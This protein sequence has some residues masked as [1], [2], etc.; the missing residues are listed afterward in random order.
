MAM[1]DDH[2]LPFRDGEDDEKAEGEGERKRLFE[3]AIPEIFKRVVERAVVAG[4]GKLAE[5][6]ESIR[7]LMG[8]MK[9]PKEVLS[10]IYTQIDDTK[11]DLYRVVAK[12]IRDVFERMQFADEIAKVLTKLS[13]EIRTEIRFIPNDAGSAAARGG[14]GE[15]DEEGENADEGEAPRGA[16]GLPKP[17]VSTHVTVKDRSKDAR[18]PSRRREDT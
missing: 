1:A 2:D 18:R 14:G 6:P 12:E 16:T 9:L 7:H 17:E 3:R 11:G 10:Y 4:V 15:G 13:F 8:E 5:S